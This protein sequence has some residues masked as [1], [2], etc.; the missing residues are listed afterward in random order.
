MPMRK[1][2]LDAPEGESASRPLAG[3]GACPPAAPAAREST[4]VRFNVATL[5]LLASAGRSPLGA[6]MSLEFLQQLLHGSPLISWCVGALA[7][8]VVV[9]CLAS[10]VRANLDWWNTRPIRPRQERGDGGQRRANRAK[11]QG[12]R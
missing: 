10:I 6:G 8:L 4:V 9:N 5:P 1:R 3:S 7:V 12:R 2:T 11:R